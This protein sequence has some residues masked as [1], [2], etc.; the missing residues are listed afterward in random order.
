MLHDVRNLLAS[1]TDDEYQHAWAERIAMGASVFGTAH[2]LA[3][4]SFPTGLPEQ[5]LR[6]RLC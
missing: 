4:A 6:H 1:E 5:E 3:L 2:T